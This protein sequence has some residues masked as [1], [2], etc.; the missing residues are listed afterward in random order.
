MRTTCLVNNYNYRPYVGE[1]VDS[2][3][4]QT[5]PFDEIIVVDDGST[6]DSVLFLRREYAAEPRVKIVAKQNEGQLSAFNEGVRHATGDL[7]FF[8]DADDRYRTVYLSEAM[9]VYEDRP[10]DFAIAGVKMFGPATEANFALQ[11]RRDLG[12]SALASLLGR[13]YVGGPTS[14]LSM[15]RQIANF[16]LPYDQ[17]EDWV[18]RADDVLILGASIAG[19][20]KY[21]LG[22]ALVEYR[23]HGNN[24]YSGQ[25]SNVVGKYAHALAVNRLVRWCAERAGFAMDDLP[26]MLHREFAT[27]ERPTGRELSAYLWMSWR[28]KLTL[29]VRARHWGTM[30]LHFAKEIARPSEPPREAVRDQTE[31][32]PGTISI[33][34]RRAA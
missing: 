20:R 4:A 11:P 31:V 19:A 5:V 21:H 10:I 32:V 23:Q 12:Y 27:I 33:E 17:V 24:Y 1:A 25:L 16:V 7:L 13:A 26:M 30:A 28:A 9:A 14:A 34:Q 3:L 18:T 2:A 8:L 22:D 29:R 6:D 15:R